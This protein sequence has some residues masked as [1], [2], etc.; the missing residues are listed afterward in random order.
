[1]TEGYAGWLAFAMQLWD[2]HF[3]GRFRSEHP[4]NFAPLDAPLDVPPSHYL[5]RQS[6]ATFIGRVGSQRQ[7]DEG[8]HEGRP[9]AATPCN[10]ATTL[11][12]AG[13]VDGAKVGLSAQGG[14]LVLADGV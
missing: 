9:E 6:H 3:H 10:R 2:H 8:P 14:A 1:M 5:K 7:N 11:F 12:R 4:V 13:S